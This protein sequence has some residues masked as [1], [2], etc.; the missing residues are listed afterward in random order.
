MITLTIDGRQ[1]EAQEGQNVLQVALDAGLDIPHLCYHEGLSAYGGCRLC[2]VE[3]TKG[4]RTT[5]TASCTYPALEGIVVETDSERVRKAR[6]LVME[7][8]LPMAPD[9]PRIRELAAKLGVTGNRFSERSG[10]TKGCIN[11]GLCVRACSELVGAHAITFAK[12]G[13]R[14][15]VEPPFEEEPENCIGC[16]ACVV[17]CPTDCIKMLDDGNARRIVRWN[18][19][20]KMETCEVCGRPFMPVAQVEFAL[21]RAAE[22]LEREWFKK[23]PDCRQ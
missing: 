14:R 13:S 1:Y 21:Q 18:R 5:L 20:L 12:R 23:C 2:L 7:L 3:V 6:K 15:T 10:D 11:C 19:T 8:L 9:A 16:G 22:P 17:V 4:K